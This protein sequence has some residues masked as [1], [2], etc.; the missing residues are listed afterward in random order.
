MGN[1]VPEGKIHRTG[2]FFCKMKAEL[3]SFL[4]TG[5]DLVKMD[6]PSITSRMPYGALVTVNI[7]GLFF[8]FIL[9]K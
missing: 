3:D 7:T 6:T 2:S 5:I 9:R 8:Y 4:C 1:V